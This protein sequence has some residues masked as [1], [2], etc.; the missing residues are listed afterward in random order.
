MTTT[1]LATRF[2]E[3]KEQ[4]D[5]VTKDLDTLKVLF[6]SRGRGR[7]AVEPRGRGAPLGALRGLRGR[8][9]RRVGVTAGQEDR[10]GFKN[11]RGHRGKRADAPAQNGQGGRGR[12]QT[13]L[14]HAKKLLEGLCFTCGSPDHM[15]GDDACKGRDAGED[16]LTCASKLLGSTNRAV[17]DHFLTTPSGQQLIDKRT[18]FDNAKE[19]L[20][21][22][23]YTCG[24][25]YHRSSDHACKG[26]KP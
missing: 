3:I 16:N 21:G 7:G 6:H 12:Q 18:A 20:K 23:C 24:S 4:S 8:G 1:S 9:N 25:P 26:R 13:A 14:D 15:S 5:T 11:S 19:L 22:L 10:G 2:Q 17:L